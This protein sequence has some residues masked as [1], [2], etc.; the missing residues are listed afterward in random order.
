MKPSNKFDASEILYTIHYIDY[1][2]G[3]LWVYGLLQ[4]DTSQEKNFIPIKTN[5]D[6]VNLIKFGMSEYNLD[7]K[8]IWVCACGSS[9]IGA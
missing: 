3:G 5:D 9:L 1:H 4:I 7:M 2:E 6:I 8:D